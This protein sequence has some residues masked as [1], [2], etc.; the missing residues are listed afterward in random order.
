MVSPAAN[1]HE[2][3]PHGPPRAPAGPRSSQS[4]RRRGVRD[5]I[6]FSQ[7]GSTFPARRIDGA[8]LDDK[9]QFVVRDG[10]DVEG[11]TGTDALDAQARN[12]KTPRRVPARGLWWS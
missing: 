9:G 8:T 11:F 5:L 12:W 6:G 7:G 10:T 4:P 3:Q 2:G 1:P